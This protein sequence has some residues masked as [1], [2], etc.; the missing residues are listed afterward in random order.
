MKLQSHKGGTRAEDV[1]QPTKEK[2]EPSTENAARLP[3]MKT[4][5]GRKSAMAVMPATVAK[6]RPN[7][8]AAIVSTSGPARHTAFVLQHSGCHVASTTQ[9]LWSK[10][11][12]LL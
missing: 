7:A 8:L 6:R 1:L 10:F 2:I 5:A 9:M 11:I 4:A 3:P 12:A